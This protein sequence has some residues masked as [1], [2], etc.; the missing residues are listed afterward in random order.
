MNLRHFS[1][2]EFDSPDMP[3]SGDQMKHGTLTMLDKARDIANVPFYIVSGYRM[4]EHN[5]M[6]GGVEYSAHCDGYAADIQYTSE[7]SAVRIIA[8]LT[9]AGF[10][11]IGKGKTFIHADNDPNKSAAYW[12]YAQ[13]HHI[14]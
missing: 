5:R 11:R 1:L 13:A 7:A 14:A 4:V 12:D 3:G 2:D 6:V 8:A 9:R 10:L